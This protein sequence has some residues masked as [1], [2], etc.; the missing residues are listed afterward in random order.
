M[1]P[2]ARK[3]SQWVSY[4][5]AAMIRRKSQLVRALNLGG[6][7]VWALDLDDF[8]NYCGEGEYPLLSQIRHTLKDP[9]KDHEPFRKLFNFC[10]SN[11]KY[12]YA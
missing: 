11:L 2:F 3:D 10:Y 4:D 8:Q 1:G 12:K 6:A 9:P 5:D 7:M